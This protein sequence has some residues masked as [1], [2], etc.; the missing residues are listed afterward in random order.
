VFVDMTFIT[1]MN[2]QEVA[3]SLHHMM[4]HASP[5]QLFRLDIVD[6]SAQTEEPSTLW[7]RPIVRDPVSTSEDGSQTVRCITEEGD[8]ID[9][10]I[11]K[12]HLRETRPAGVT[13]TPRP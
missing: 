11:G 1:Q 5:E 4:H 8:L 10:F 6:A 7:I 9:I 13:T 3:D 2:A 12:P